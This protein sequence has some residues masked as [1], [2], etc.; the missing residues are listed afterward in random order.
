MKD[1]AQGR[2]QDDD[3]IVIRFGKAPCVHSEQYCYTEDGGKHIICL[4]CEYEAE[5]AASPSA[6]V[7][8]IAPS[9]PSEFTNELRSCLAL[10][11][12]CVDYQRGACSVNEMVGAVLDKTVLERAR[13]VVEKSYGR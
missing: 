10:I 12:D 8:S 2:V 5:R 9:T 3:D 13:K 6:T 7:P 1:E 4:V 11:L